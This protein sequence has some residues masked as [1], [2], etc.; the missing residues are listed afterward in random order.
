M[1]CVRYV[2]KD[3]R[4]RVTLVRALRGL[5][6]EIP[7]Q[8][9]GHVN[10]PPAFFS[11]VRYSSQQHD[12]PVSSWIFFSSSFYYSKIDICGGSG[13]QSVPLHFMR[14]RR[15]PKGQIFDPS[16]S[17]DGRMDALRVK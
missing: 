6:A 17:H 13:G 1:E 4:L 2:K 9:T 12:D 16:I 5:E 8:Q 3:Q 7:L 10:D 15:D 11:P 14:K